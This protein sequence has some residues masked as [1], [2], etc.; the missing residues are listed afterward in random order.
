MHKK[1]RWGK[2][3]LAILLTAALL[4]DTNTV[5]LAEEIRDQV[6]KIQE[7][8][9]QE[10]AWQKQLQE[11]ETQVLPGQ[12]EGD[13]EK[14]EEASD[15]DGG[16]EQQEQPPVSLR[17]PD[18]A[19]HTDDQE[20]EL[21]GR[22]GEPVEIDEHKKVYQADATHYVTRITSE[23]NTC[24]TE[25][26]EETQTDLTLVPRDQDTGELCEMP[27]EEQIRSTD[28][29]IV[30]TPKASGLEVRLPANVTETEG[31]CISSQEHTLELF[32]EEGTFGNA[33][34]REN[35]LLYN[36]VQEETDVQYTVG[37]TGIKEDIILNQWTGQHTFRYTFDGKGYEAEASANQILIREKGKEEILFVLSAPVMVDAGGQESREIEVSL[38]REGDRFQV[39][40]DAD[41]TWLSEDGR[42]YPV[43]IDPTV[44]VPTESLIEVTTSTVHGTYQGEG[45]GYAGYITSKMTG[46]PGAKDIGRSRMYYAVN[47]DFAGSI[48]KE[49]RIDSATLDVYQYVQYPQTNATF[50]CYRINAPWKAGSLTWDSSVVLPLEPSGENCTSGAKHGMHHFDIRETVNNWV[51]GTAPNYGLVVMATD[52]SAYGGAFY[53]P[54]STGTEGQSDFSWDK[55]PGITIHWSVPDPVD[56][57]YGVDDT[58]VNLRSM[59]LTDRNGKLQFQGVFADG[60]AAPG[61][62]V[63]YTLNDPAKNYAGAAYAGYSYKYPDS[64]GFDSAFEK[65][66]TTYKDKLGNWQTLY[67]FTAPD[68]NV[69]YRI[70]A[71]AVKGGKAGKEN[72]SED[73]VIYKVT[74]YDTLPKIA[75]YYGVPLAQI[76][77]DNR[78]QDMLLVENNTLFIRNPKK[79]ATVPYNPPALDDDEKARIDAALMG[80]GLHCEFGFEPVNL[81]TGNFYLNRTDVTIPDYTGDFAIERNYNSKG[82]GRNSVFGRGWSFAY[83]EQLSKAADGS[84]RYTRDDGSVLIFTEENGAYKSPDGYG[85]TL[86]KQKIRENTWDFGAGEETY[87]VYTYT[88]TDREHTVK[89]F[90]CFGMLAS[91]CDEKGNQTTLVY[92]ENQNLTK[93][94]SPAGTEY[95][96]KTSEEGYITAV[97]LPNGSS[98]SYTYDEEGNLVSYTD[99]NGALTRYEYDEQHRMT[100]W[101]D[102]NGARIVWNAYDPEGRVI[103][104]T[105]ANGAVS[106]LAYGEGTT[107]TTDANGNQTIYTFDDTCRTVKITNPD[108]TTR[109]MDYNSQNLLAS[110]TDELGHTTA[111]QYDKDGN[112]ICETRFDGAVR[113]WNYDQ[114][115]H[116]TEAVGYDGVVTEY[117]YDRYGNLETI[118]I[119]GNLQAS[120]QYDHQGRIKSSTDATAIRPPIPIPGQT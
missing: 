24:R 25:D 97:G 67:P 48:P 111:H 59:I 69:P 65:G 43:K 41:E 63:G 120:Y 99:A 114:D 80:R 13:L 86:E 62:I 105:D 83:T 17:L 74:R 29:A 60:T 116:V 3:I 19:C 109:S 75:N 82:A 57:N 38:E 22:Y 103:R 46:V 84:I 112:E 76:M 39:T 85:L 52:E 115:H 18:T 34:V 91:I 92:D 20:A 113:T 45:Y 70:K 61:S 66:T 107:T 31:I 100:A 5:V 101:Y 16:A 93:I 42:T 10:H 102:G 2:R 79:N 78:V 73:F 89:T 27:T 72:T 117:T 118:T 44:T 51:Q 110:E 21:E 23:A 9:Q 28:L 54:Y 98:L 11:I 35:A 106:T 71:Q 55:R 77:Y 36:Q 96:I 90:D 4:S 56:E 7:E 33:T 81:N 95:Q 68:F 32:P 6:I 15:S 14:P 50:A 26:G 37:T 1:R 64:S 58:T 40:I 87:P 53:T 12:T 49:A 94:Q 30:Y 8:Y 119:D 47:Y 88:I 104:Q 108:G